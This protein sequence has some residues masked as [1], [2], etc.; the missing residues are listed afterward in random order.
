[1]DG[2]NTVP[3]ILTDSS[4]NMMSQKVKGFDPL[5]WRNIGDDAWYRTGT[6]A[7]SSAGQ[8]VSLNKQA[9]AGASQRALTGR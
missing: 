3:D 8:T 9:A 1:M 2:I 7:G 5:G 6:L 4:I